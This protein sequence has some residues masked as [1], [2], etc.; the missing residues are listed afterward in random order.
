MKHDSRFPFQCYTSK[1]YI[2]QVVI[3]VCLEVWMSDPNLLTPLY[4]FPI[5]LIRELGRITG[6]L[7]V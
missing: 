3:S 2:Y 7:L 6:M 5:T 4:H 1:N